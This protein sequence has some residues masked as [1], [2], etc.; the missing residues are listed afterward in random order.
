M[1]PAF[2]AQARRAFARGVLQ[3]YRIEE[4][5]SLVV[6]GRILFDEQ[7]RRRFGK[8]PPV[9]VRFDDFTEDIEANRLVKAAARRLGRLRIRAESSRRSLNIIESALERVSHIQYH[10][11]Q[12]PEISFS[13][14]NAHYR[15]VLM[16]SKL[17]LAVEEP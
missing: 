3:G 4:E 9:E 6:R 16:L 7:L 1:I 11:R 13:R 5:S 2:V 14:L 8:T 17:I 15:P 10:P 12:L